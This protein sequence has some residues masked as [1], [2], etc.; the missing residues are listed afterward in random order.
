L[1]AKYPKQDSQKIKFF[2]ILAHL[3]KVILQDAAALM[4]INS[5]PQCIYSHH[6][7]FLEPIFKSPLFNQFRVDLCEKMATSK[8]PV[9]DS[10]LANAPAI[11]HGLRDISEKL[12]ALSNV[13]QT[14][15]TTTQME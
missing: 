1:A 3:R 6:R 14:V 11:Q 12:T 15:P 8:S 7:M 10:L 13:L 5:D 9:T 4:E 2:I